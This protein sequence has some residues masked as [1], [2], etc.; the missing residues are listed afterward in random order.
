MYSDFRLQRPNTA[1][2]PDFWPPLFQKNRKADLLMADGTVSFST[3]VS[4]LPAT[5]KTRQRSYIVRPPIDRPG[6]W[7]INTSHIP[8]SI[9]L[10]RT[11]HAI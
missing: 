11:L 3:S 4:H 6:E 1:A 5:S 10:H 2:L 8:H 9:H 7:L